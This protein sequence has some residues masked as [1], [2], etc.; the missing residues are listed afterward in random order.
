MVPFEETGYE[1]FMKNDMPLFQ[2]NVVEDSTFL[3]FDGLPIHYTWA[4]RP[5]ARATIVVVHGFTEYYGKYHELTYNFYE[6]GFNFF[7]IENRGHGLS[8]REIE[9]RNLVHVNRFDDYIEDLKIFMD[10]IVEP[11]AP[12]TAKILFAHSMGGAI[13]AGFLEKYPEHF[14][15]A[16][17]SS[18]MLKMSYGN[19]KTWQ[20]YLLAGIT[21]IAHWEKKALPN[22]ETFDPDRP[23]FKNSCTTSEARYMYGFNFRKENL[24]AYSTYAGTFG[25]A[26]ESMT[27]TDEI[28]KKADKVHIPVLLLQAG[29]D[30]VVDNT[31]E[32]E[33]S[34]RARHCILRRFSA[35]KH[36]IYNSTAPTLSRYYSMI[37][38][39]LRQIS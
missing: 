8:G 20:A 23:D 26:R 16:I 27:A 11:S 7:F 39:F 18:P 32:N 24:D 35:A 1:T 36:E 13:G 22:A 3:S 33:F 25:W 19:I 2:K 34:E 28:R 30:D 9:D 15:A 14:K 37:F 5:D 6:Q 29:K 21:P 12:G 17:L 38:R 4:L 31:G 10:R